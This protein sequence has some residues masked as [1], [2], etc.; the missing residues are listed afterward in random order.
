MVPQERQGILCMP[1]SDIGL[2][3]SLSVYN[4][5]LS[6]GLTASSDLSYGSDLR[7]DPPHCM[8]SPCAPTC[9]HRMRLS[10]LSSI[11]YT[12]PDRRQGYIGPEHGDLWRYDGC[13]RWVSS[14]FS[15]S[16]AT[17]E[18]GKRFRCGSATVER[19]SDFHTL[20]PGYFSPH[21]SGLLTTGT[22]IANYAPH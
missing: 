1:Y 10:H 16:F 22:L 7:K 14:T 13:D 4:T 18:S 2:S 15:T 5:K 19:P 11:R 17:P 9:H 6:R 20:F 21:A 3:L 12:E 8:S